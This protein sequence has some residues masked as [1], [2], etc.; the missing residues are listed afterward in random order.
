VKFQD[1]LESVP[2]RFLYDLQE[3]LALCKEMREC[4]VSRNFREGAVFNFPQDLRASL[5]SIPMRGNT[6]IV[7]SRLFRDRRVRTAVEP[8]SLRSTKK[9]L[10][11]K[12]NVPFRGAAITIECTEED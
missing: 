2:H 6:R 8:F 1:I 3:F 4:G 9:R 5:A 7:R 11:L 12:T 10:L